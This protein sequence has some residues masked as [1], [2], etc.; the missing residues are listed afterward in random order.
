MSLVALYDKQVEKHPSVQN[1]VRV[2]ILSAP[3]SQSRLNKPIFTWK[4][5]MR[6]Q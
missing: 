3:P 6:Y 2:A 4:A 1:T 5:G